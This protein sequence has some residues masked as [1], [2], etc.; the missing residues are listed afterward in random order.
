[1]DNQIMDDTSFLIWDK[2]EQQVYTES[3]SQIER[4]RWEHA[5][6]MLAFEVWNQVRDQVQIH[7]LGQLQDD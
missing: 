7:I 4:K 3:Y 5:W 1:M 2:E 6:H